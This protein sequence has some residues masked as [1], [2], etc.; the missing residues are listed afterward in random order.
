MSLMN[1]GN[2]HSLRAYPPV[3]NKPQ[4]SLYVGRAPCGKSAMIDSPRIRQQGR[5]KNATV[6]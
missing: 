4:S 6:K 1:I 2:F 3:V 5:G